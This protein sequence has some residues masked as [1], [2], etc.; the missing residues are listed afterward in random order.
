M[1]G[2]IYKEEMGEFAQREFKSKLK[3]KAYTNAYAAYVAP[4]KIIKEKPST[5]GKKSK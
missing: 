5:Q 1:P 4:A 3:G 2:Q